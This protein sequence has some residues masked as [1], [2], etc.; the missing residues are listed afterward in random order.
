VVRAPGFC[1]ERVEIW[2]YGHWICRF[3]LRTAID[4]YPDC[5]RIVFKPNADADRLN[6]T[7][8]FAV[9]FS[10]TV[11]VHALGLAQ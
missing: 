8:V 9:R 11:S 4:R 7:E 10:S 2:E 5:V 1:G 3:S 6:T